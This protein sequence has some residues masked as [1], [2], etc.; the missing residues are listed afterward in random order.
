[1]IDGQFLRKNRW[2]IAFVVLPTLLAAFYYFFLASDRYVSESRFTVKSE[3]ERPSQI[4]SLASI[5]QTTGLSSGQEQTSE[6]LDYIRSRSALAELSSQMNIRADYNASHADFLSRYPT[7]FGEDRFENLYRYYSRMIEAQID[8]NTGLAVLTVQAFTPGDAQRIN[9]QLLELSERLVNRLNEKARDKSVAENEKLVAIAEQRVKNARLALAAYRNKNNLLD[10]SKQ[11]LGV[12]DISSKLVSQQ[13][14]LQ[15]QLD[16]MRRVAPDN[17]AIPSLEK[18]IGAL[19]EQV[20]EQNGRAVGP[21]SSIASKLTSYEGL[22]LEQEFASQMLT[23]ANTQLAQ[24][25]AEA[26]RQQYYLERVVEPSAPDMGTL[27]HRFVQVLVIAGVL[28]CL[29]LV[30]WMLIVGIL[31]HAPED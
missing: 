23:S 27:P 16:M 4:S 6:V 15:A 7:L 13:A 1:M 21:D 11:A 22:T 12:F 20:S 8:P 5:I 17:P 2:F 25:R 24:A 29:Y 30:G 3:S 9:S 28:L 26:I 14:T 10:P 31:E 18:Q 19:S